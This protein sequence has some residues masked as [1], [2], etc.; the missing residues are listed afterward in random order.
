[1]KRLAYI[2]I[3]VLVVSVSLPMAASP[4]ANRETITTLEWGRRLLSVA[5]S[6]DGK[7]L[8]SGDLRWLRI[9][10]IN[11]GTELHDL[12]TAGLIFSLGWSP[13]GNYIASG[14]SRVVQIWDV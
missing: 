1:M 14:S 9:W 8:A 5:W 11:S 2:L 10:D 3:F 13:D 6:P 12:E 4:F 7:H